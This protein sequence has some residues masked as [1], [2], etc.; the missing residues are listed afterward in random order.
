MKK[1]ITLLMACAFV[2]SAQ[3]AK[4]A[5]V[6]VQKVL[7]TVKEGKK[8]RENKNISVRMERKKVHIVKP[9]HV[10]NMCRGEKIF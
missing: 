2:F 9:Q 1:M 8:V 6:D 10:E 7:L 3:A 4:V 5:K